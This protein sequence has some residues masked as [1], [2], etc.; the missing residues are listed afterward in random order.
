MQ[1]VLIGTYFNRLDADLDAAVLSAAGIPCYVQAAELIPGLSAPGQIKI[2]VRAEDAA[3]AREI[4]EAPDRAKDRERPVRVGTYPSDAKAR[5][6]AALLEA[7]GIPFFLTDHDPR[8]ET[9]AQLFV[10]PRDA[11]RARHA[12]GERRR[13]EGA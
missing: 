9:D 2:V 10:R 13:G 11:Q 8:G 3:E 1:T 6:A 5:Q 7:S 4:L 12:L